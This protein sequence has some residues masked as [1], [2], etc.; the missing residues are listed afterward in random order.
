MEFCGCPWAWVSVP[1]PQKGMPPWTRSAFCFVLPYFA[2]AA[3]GTISLYARGEDYH[4]VAA[5]ILGAFEQELRKEHPCMQARVF[6]DSCRFDERKLALS[7]GLG[8][9]GMNGL[10]LHPEY[11]S[12]VFLAELLTDLPCDELPKEECF[13][14]GCGA[15]LRACPTKALEPSGV[16]TARSNEKRLS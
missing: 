14:E 10:F 9:R 16:D 3:E 8:M 15:C 2:G 4:A 7:A 13:C 1:Q 5:R 12:Y 6:C 11:G